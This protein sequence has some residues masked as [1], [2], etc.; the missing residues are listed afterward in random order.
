MDLLNIEMKKSFKKYN[1]NPSEIPIA[2]DEIN[3]MF[4]NLFKLIFSLLLN[5]LDIKGVRASEITSDNIP[6]ARNILIDKKYSPITDFAK[7]KDRIKTSIC[8]KNK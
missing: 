2:I 6:I 5:T 7:K 8:L 4:L 1:K 3:M